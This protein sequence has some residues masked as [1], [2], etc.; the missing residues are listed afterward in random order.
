M[1]LLCIISFFL[2]ACEKKNKQALDLDLPVTRILKSNQ[3]PWAVISS[4]YVRLRKQPGISQDY[5][6]T[7]W[8]GSILQVLA[9]GE[10]KQKIEGADD[11]WFKV[12]YQGLRGWIFGAYL[13]KCENQ[14][15]AGHLADQYKKQPKENG[16]LD[17]Q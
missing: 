9:I 12:R 16:D 14:E 8:Q 5:I 3:M 15:E 11:Y 13:N 10:E 17:E 4:P 2:I 7:L 1:I 6:A